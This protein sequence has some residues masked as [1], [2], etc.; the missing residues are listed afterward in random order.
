[1]VA[2]TLPAGN[3]TEQGYPCFLSISLYII[4]VHYLQV[5]VR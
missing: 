1:M 5:G 4:G 3:I 2:T